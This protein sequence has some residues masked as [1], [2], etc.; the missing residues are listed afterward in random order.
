MI[1]MVDG[2][3]FYSYEIRSGRVESLSLHELYQ[4]NSAS[5]VVINDAQFLVSKWA[6]ATNVGVYLSDE[7]GFAHVKILASTLSKS[8]IFPISGESC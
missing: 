4:L 2:E 8:S 6:L 1:W 3:N 5:K 7:Q